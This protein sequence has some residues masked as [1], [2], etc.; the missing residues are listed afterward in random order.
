MYSMGQTQIVIFLNITNGVKQ[1]GVI[2]PRMF[3]IYIDQ[4]LLRLEKSGIGCHI[5]GKCMG[6]LGYSDDVILLSPSI[7]GLH[8]MLSI[9]E[10]FD[11]DYFIQFNSKKINVHKIW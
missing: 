11:K 6:I 5:H 3:T 7:R 8:R 10:E 9:C 2:S 4:L 1:G